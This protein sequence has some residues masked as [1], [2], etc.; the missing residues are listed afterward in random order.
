VLP[1]VTVAR[2]LPQLDRFGITRMADVTGLD[3]I[4]LPVVTVCRPNSRS[5]TVAM[6]KGLDRAA[7]KSSG[8]M[9]AVEVAHAEVVRAPLRLLPLRL[10]AGAAPAIDPLPPLRP[11]AAPLE[12]EVP[13][14][15][16]EGVELLRGGAVSVPLEAVHASF[17]PPALPQAGTF[18][19]STNGLASGNHPLEALCH[20]LCEVIERD[21]TARWYRLG[22][23]GR[24]ASRLDLA[25]L[26]DGE[27]AGVLARLTAG[28]FEAA[29]WDTTSPGGVASF[30]CLLLDARFPQAHP[31][32][33][34]GCH[35][36]REVALLRALL[37]AAQVRLAYVVG[38]RDDIEPQE[39]AASWLETRLARARALIA[40]GSGGRALSAVP[41]VTTG[42]SAEDVDLLRAA[43]VK[44]GAR[45]AVLVDLTWPGVGIPVVRVVVPDLLDEDD[46]GGDRA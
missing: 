41:T 23:A 4:G 19:V 25:T 21:A 1:E 30:Y 26:G 42:S 31:G 33:G 5:V 39:Y 18:R 15:W 29:V 7:A 8:L 44:L 38:A 37:E 43:L 20:G 28:G 9:E 27:A 40:S 22:R 45:T 13:C 17:A 46:E 35:P 10:L 3:R 14:L 34:A 12:G 6:G 2:L 24:A 11:G 32:E 16:I 36:E